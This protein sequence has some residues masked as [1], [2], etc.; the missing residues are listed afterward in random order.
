LW[1]VALARLDANYLGARTGTW[2]V[3]AGA[4]AVMGRGFSLGIALLHAGRGFESDGGR[5]PLPTRIRPG[6]AWQGR[7]GRLHA[8]VVADVPVPARLDSPPDL[9]TGVELRGNGGP[10]APRPA[11]GIAP[12]RTV[13]AA[14]RDRVRGRWGVASAWAL[15]PPTSRTP[16]GQCS[17]TIA[18]FP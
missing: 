16:L 6:A 15:S 12:L 11:P 13:T 10:S 2:A 9:H 7:L 14:V 18:S 1:G 8:A 3:D 5:A 17:E 4:Q